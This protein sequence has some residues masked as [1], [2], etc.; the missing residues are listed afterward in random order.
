MP[1]SPPPE[2]AFEP[3]TTPQVAAQPQENDMARMARMASDD[4]DGGVIAKKDFALIA[5]LP[6]L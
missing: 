1:Q 4:D 6:D 5:A 2:E 3:I